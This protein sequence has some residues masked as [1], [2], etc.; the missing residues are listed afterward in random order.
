MS[1]FSAGSCAEGNRKRLC[2]VGVVQGVM[3]A[4]ECCP[5]SEWVV[6]TGAQVF[7]N[8]SG[9][10]KEGSKHTCTHGHHTCT[11]TH[12]YTHT[13]THTRTY[14]TQIDTNANIHNT[15][16]YAHLYVRMWLRFRLKYV[17]RSSVSL[18]V[19]SLQA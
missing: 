15:H 19:S 11:H 2:D 17:S 6:F 8:I 12:T 3:A 1:V 9:T 5:H 10:G 13:H 7:Q 4:F 18:C 14:M 16:T